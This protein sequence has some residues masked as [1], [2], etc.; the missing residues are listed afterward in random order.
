VLLTPL[1]QAEELCGFLTII[2]QYEPI[3]YIPQAGTGDSVSQIQTTNSTMA[4][5]TEEMFRNATISLM[6]DVTEWTAKPVY[7]YNASTLWIV[8]GIAIGLSFLSVISGTIVVVISRA[9]YSSQ[10]STI[11]R[12]SHH[13]ELPAQVEPRD[14][15]GKYPLPKYLQ[16][17]VLQ[18]PP[19]NNTK[20]S[21]S[22]P[23]QQERDLVQIPL[24]W[25]RRNDSSPEPRF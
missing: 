3:N 2:T 6:A 13:V 5:L 16:D 4:S 22:S 20:A 1:A 8:Y 15:S 11:L 10:F 9:S 19:E 23:S 12:V 17:A 14:A 25:R 7:Q 21:S 18:F 24:L